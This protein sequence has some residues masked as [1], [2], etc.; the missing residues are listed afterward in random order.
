MTLTGRGEEG[1][2]RRHRASATR[3]RKVAPRG[4]HLADEQVSD[5]QTANLVKPLHAVRDHPARGLLP[6]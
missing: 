6:A 2:D 1:F 4:T 5:S 3:M